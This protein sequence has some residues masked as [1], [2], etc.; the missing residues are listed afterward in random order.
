M[1]LERA[2]LRWSVL[3]ALGRRGTA[4]GVCGCFRGGRG[5]V[6]LAPT[7]A[8]F[9]TRSEFGVDEPAKCPG[10]LIVFNTACSCGCN[11]GHFSS[12]SK[13]TAPSIDGFA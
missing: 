10:S 7:P 3:F 2:H 6:R 12:L 13:R 4:I 11:L 8:S 9:E 5:F 1:T